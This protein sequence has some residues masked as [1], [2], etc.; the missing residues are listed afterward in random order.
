MF[1]S[2]LAGG[3][4]SFIGCPADLVLIRMQA[5][6]MLPV[7]QRRNYGNVLNAFR[8]IPAEEGI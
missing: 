7:E 1:C 6:K 3:L 5:D 8:R 2:L 4:G